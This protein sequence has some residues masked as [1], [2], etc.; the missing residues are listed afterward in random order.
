[1]KKIIVFGIF[2]F[3]CFIGL[4]CLQ[5]FQFSDGKFHVVFCDVGQG[6]AIFLSTPSGKH[7][8]LDGGPDESVFACLSSHMPF[9]K[10]TIDLMILSHP[11]AD[12]VNG[13]VSV[14]DRYH[15]SYFATEPLKNNTAGYK[16]L[17]KKVKEKQVRSKSLLA[18]NVIRMGDGVVIHIL[19]PTQEYLDQTSPNGAIGE[20]VEFGSLIQQISYGSVD[21]LVTGDSQISGMKQAEQKVKG[22]IEVL[23]APHHGSRFGLDNAL[24]DG[25]DPKIAVFSVGKNMY[26]HPAPTILTLLQNAGITYLR[27]DMD[28][29]VEIVSD[30]KKFWVE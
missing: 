5:L 30:G 23:Q 6:D 20:S 11:H 24:V 16:E 7:I 15:V 1:M 27:T 13:L 26:G 3:F 28:G 2:I 25:I 21:I 4:V 19:G 14:L 22:E 18:G 9:W 10:K 17:L 8:L 12:H 29:D